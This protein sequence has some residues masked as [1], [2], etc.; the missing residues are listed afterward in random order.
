MTEVAPSAAPRLALLRNIVEGPPVNPETSIR[1]D[2]PAFVGAEEAAFL[3][4]ERPFYDEEAP[5]DFFVT[6]A[7]GECVTVGDWAALVVGDAREVAD[8]AAAFGL[9]VDLMG[10]Y[11]L[12]VVLVEEGRDDDDDDAGSALAVVA[13]DSLVGGEASE[14]EH[15][16]QIA[17]VRSALAE[18]WCQRRRRC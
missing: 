1:F 5:V 16:P 3:D 10:H 12:A 2:P 11:F 18:A 15:C 14:F 13:V 6:L 8:G 7:G 17:T 4:Q 9:I